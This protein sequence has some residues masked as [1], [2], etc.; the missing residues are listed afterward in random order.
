MVYNVTVTQRELSIKSGRRREKGMTS[1]APVGGRIFF[2]MLI[3]LLSSVLIM[4]GFSFVMIMHQNNVSV[5]THVDVLKA[6]MAGSAAQID[7]F[8]KNSA[9]NW[10][11]SPALSW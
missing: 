11:Q 7:G 3:A 8:W 4:A 6:A 1:K 10:F 2:R 5:Q 9:S